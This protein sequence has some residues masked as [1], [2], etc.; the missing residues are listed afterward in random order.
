LAATASE[1]RN[2]M[3][4]KATQIQGCRKVLVAS[5]TAVQ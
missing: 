3:E 5:R 2:A 4:A 1:T